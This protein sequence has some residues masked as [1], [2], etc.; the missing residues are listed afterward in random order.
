MRLK[1]TRLGGII[2]ITTSN[3]NLLRKRGA[4]RLQNNA[5]ELSKGVRE[6]KVARDN[7]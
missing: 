3:P 7:T 2:K 4:R 1:G 6:Q 5:V